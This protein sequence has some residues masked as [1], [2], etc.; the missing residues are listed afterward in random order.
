[1]FVSLWSVWFLGAVF[2]SVCVFGSVFSWFGALSML[3]KV[4]FNVVKRD[5]CHIGFK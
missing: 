2:G 1:M 5:S 3:L 4:T